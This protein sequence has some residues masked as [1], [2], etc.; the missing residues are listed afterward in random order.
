MPY[1]TGDKW[2]NPSSLYAPA[3]KVKQDVDKARKTVA[4]FIGA[5]AE[6]I[7]FESSATEANNHVIRGWDDLHAGTCSLIV[8]TPIEHKSIMMALENPSLWSKVCYCDVDEN[9][10]VKLDALCDIL[11]EHKSWDVLVTIGAANSEIGTV[12]P[13]EKIAEI[14]HSYKGAVFHTDATQLLPHQ[15]IDVHEVEIDMLSASAQKFGGLKGTGFLYKNK[16]VDI[17]TLIWGSQ[18]NGARGATE[19]VAGIIGMAKAIELTECDIK[20]VKAMELMRDCLIDRLEQI[21]CKLNGSRVKRLPNNVNVQTGVNAESL[22]YMLDM[23]NIMI[24]TGSACNSKSIE[25]SYVLKAIG[26][27]DDEANSSIRLT[28]SQDTTFEEIDE[29][30]CE[31]ERCIKLIKGETITW[32]GNRQT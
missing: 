13:I 21:G 31:I 18:E 28:I 19:N 8:S 7:I 14:V 15:K 29:V 2:Y 4:D 27:G 5:D 17:A 6:E 23:S 32:N 22:L 16:D 9:G 30:V 25:P 3:V 24:A 10:I 11:E 26:L 12:Q 20:N 1:L